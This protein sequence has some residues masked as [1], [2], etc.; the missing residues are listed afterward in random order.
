LA[1]SREGDKA[2]QRKKDG[3][4]AFRK[5]VKRRSEQ[6]GDY[7][8][9]QPSICLRIIETLKTAALRD[10]PV[11]ILG[12]TGTGKKMVARQIHAHSYRA[13]NVFVPV[14]CAALT[15]QLFESQ[16]FG[17]VKGSFT[18]AVSSTL[19]SFRAAEVG[20]I[21]LDQ[22]EKLS[23]ALQA[24]L[25][26]VFLESRVTPV[27]STKSY[28]VNVRV[29]CATD[30]DLRQMVRDGNFR[31]DLYF[32]LNVLRLDLPP[33]RERKEDIIILAKYFLDRQAQLYNGHS[34]TLSPGAIK[35]LTSYNWPG[36]IQELANVM[37]QA[38][39]FSD[40]DEIRPSE[41]T[42]DIL[43]EDIV[44]EQDRGFPTLDQANKKLVINALTAT[45][46]QKMAAA[47]LLRID[48]RKLSRLIKKYNI[49]STW[50]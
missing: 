44:P 28:P 37:E 45:N 25:L 10:C 46:G 21:F 17:Y 13:E 26:G 1:D 9:W 2:V 12:E 43:T 22:I 18:G 49:Q 23:L 3:L 24:K 15:G 6:V 5:R 20:T 4:E 14:D 32:H 35:I 30:C 16:L 42:L 8:V 48:H 31:A 11:L 27:G 40:S 50:E 29:I 41:L 38:Y 7:L 19:G 36:N 33:L 34:K 47:K 39:I